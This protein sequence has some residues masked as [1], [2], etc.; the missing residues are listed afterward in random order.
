MSGSN[1]AATLTA[2]AFCWDLR[3]L[4]VLFSISFPFQSVAGC[5]RDNEKPATQLQGEREK[6]E[7]PPAER[8][9]V[10][11]WVGARTEKL[12]GKLKRRSQE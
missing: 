9:E 8:G 3:W 1:E 4:L 6:G 12:Y 10:W 11:Q 2:L 7:H 5:H